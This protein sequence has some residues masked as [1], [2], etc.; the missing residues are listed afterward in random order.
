MPVSTSSILKL[1]CLAEMW[2]SR[3]EKRHTSE[4]DNLWADFNG[5]GVSA[6][7]DTQSQVSGYW[8]QGLAHSNKGHKTPRLDST[9]THEEADIIKH[10][11]PSISPRKVQNHE[12]VW[13]VVIDTDV[14]CFANLLLEWEASV[15]QSPIQ[16]RSCVDIKETVHTHE[17][18]HTWNIGTPCVNCDSVAA[19]YGV[20]KTTASAV[21]RRGRTLDQLGQPTADIVVKVTKQ[22]TAFKAAWYGNKTPCYMKK[23]RHRLVYRHKTQYCHQHCQAL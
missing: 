7:C 12:C 10:S 2:C 4:H 17:K 8:W 13:C 14:F 6:K 15:L 11:K 21:S 19:S 16:G 20:A 3:T 5:R 23:C 9:A 1:R 18:N 22:S